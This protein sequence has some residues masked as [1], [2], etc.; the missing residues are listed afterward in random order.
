MFLHSCHSSPWFCFLYFHVFLPKMPSRMWWGLLLSW[1]MSISVMVLCEVLW[2]ET[3]AHEKAF[4]I[5]ELMQMFILYAF[6]GIR[7]LFSS[8]AF[9][10]H[11]KNWIEMKK[12]CVSHCVTSSSTSHCRKN[13]KSETSII[14]TGTR[15]N[16][17]YVCLRNWITHWSTN[18]L[19]FLLYDIEY[20]KLFIYW[21]KSIFFSIKKDLWSRR[22]VHSQ[23]LYYHL[24]CNASKFDTVL[25][26]SGI[27]F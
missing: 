5:T 22:D 20:I 8:S 3:R 25:L 26:S 18:S 12:L 27:T 4:I 15:W 1:H 16:L 24:L 6:E 23:D 7:L 9:I 2:G 19:P 21:Y 14:L 17:W 11:H 13:T 10:L